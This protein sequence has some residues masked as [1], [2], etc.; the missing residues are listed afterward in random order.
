MKIM[1]RRGS[2]PQSSMVKT[3]RPPK[4]LLG[5]FDFEKNFSLNISKCRNIGTTRLIV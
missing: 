3:A 1:V 5:I 2:D 4:V